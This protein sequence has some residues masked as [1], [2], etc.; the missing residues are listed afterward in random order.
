MPD[1]R[2]SRTSQSQ[3]R[4]AGGGREAL[5]PPSGSIHVHYT[6]SRQTGIGVVTSRPPSDLPPCR[7]WACRQGLAVDHRPFKKD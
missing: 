4:R 6:P 2:E 3:F 5:A 1:P 7:C